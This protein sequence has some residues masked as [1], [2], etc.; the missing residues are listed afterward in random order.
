MRQREGSRGEG[1]KEGKGEGCRSRSER[2]ENVAN[3]A[4]RTL[5]FK[6]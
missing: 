6:R 2:K 5:D 4:C 1:G 3:G